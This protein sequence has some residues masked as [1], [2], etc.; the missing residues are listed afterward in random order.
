LHIEVSD[1][2]PGIPHIDEVLSGRY[3]STTGLGQGLL[4]VR[5]LMDHFEIDAPA[6]GGT[7][8]AVS[9]ALPAG[10]DAPGARE[11]RDALSRRGVRSPYDEIT[12][13]NQE[14]LQ[15]FNELRAR[16]EELLALN[17]ELDDTNRGVVALYAEL[18]ERAESLRDADDRK[19][20]FLADMSHELRSPLNSIVALTELLL[21]DG[22]GGALDDEQRRQ[23]GYIRR[24]AVDQ[25]ELVGD[26]LDIAKIEAGR[27]DV[28]LRE[29]SVPELFGVL[30]AQL[31]PLVPASDVRLRFD[32]EPG[33]PPLLTDE[34]KLVQI[35]RNL[36]TNALKFTA[37]GD[38]V[39]R[40]TADTEHV[41]FTVSD[42]GVGIA[43][44]DLERI[45]EEFVQVPG[46]H[47]RNVRGT[48]LGLP[49]C[50]K[51]VGILGG[52]IRV[53]SAVGQGTTFTVR[54]PGALRADGTEAPPPGAEVL[55]VDDDE[56]AR[57]V[58]RA[59]LDGSGWA[60]REASSGL[61]ALA[62]I[63]QHVP[64]AIVLD[65]SMPDIDGLEVLRRL[66]ERPGLSDV[67]VVIHTSREIGESERRAIQRHRALLLDKA[68][69]SRASL[70]SV[71]ATA[72][73]GG[74]RG[75]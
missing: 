72:T 37:A 15:A 74:V 44:A 40:A 68:S 18:D 61:A 16:Q 12:E 4:S 56:A 69:A 62:E 27:V 71:L 70:L 59:Q 54:L 29:L 53:E 57:Y 2:G 73:A 31:R 7:R 6:G 13:Q 23:I 22:D 14:L 19:S 75:G 45:F 38:V 34:G 43:P 55:L 8:V 32:A 5:R 33:L 35:L 52:T 36:V 65:L 60:I 20:R 58:L 3:R 25:L 9:R 26:L 47:Q 1:D 11:V 42:T 63:Q 24:M 64:T 49:L 21:D 30:R 48:G 51:L 28:D 10:G 66:R 17:R 46:E 41:T 67:T 50:R 39:V